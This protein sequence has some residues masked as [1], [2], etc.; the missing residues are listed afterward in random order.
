MKLVSVII[1]SYNHA[2]FITES[3][4]SILSQSY[5]NIQ[6]IIIDDGSTDQS[7]KV[8]SNILIKTKLENTHFIKQNN[9]GVSV[10]INTGISKADGE[11]ILILAS[12]DIINPWAITEMVKKFD[13][14]EVGMVFGDASIINSLGDS[15]DIPIGKNKFTNSF[16]EWRLQKA[17]YLP[18]DFVSIR[19]CLLER[20]FIPPMIM[21][22]KEA[23]YQ[24]GD[25]S[26]GLKLED[27]EMWLRISRVY[28]ICFHDSV[29]GKY[30]VHGLNTILKSHKVLF[31]NTI[32]V[33]LK[34][35]RYVN[36]TDDMFLLNKRLARLIIS[37]IK[38]YKLRALSEGEFARQVI[39]F[40]KFL[41]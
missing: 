12:D 4:E 18:F 7:D 17:A 33:L 15:I 21:L 35:R 30:R 23:L 14:T 20:N 29:I 28:K 6:L 24:V 5:K 25:F 16:L 22:R 32:T 38:H 1:P 36:N 27:H 37:Y 34:E 31:Q 13:E 40:F 10:A 9:S 8:I 26:P 41:A 19:R 2:Q 39:D 3:I 11:Y